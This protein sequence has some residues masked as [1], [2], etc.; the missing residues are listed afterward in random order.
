M[1]NEDLIKGTTIVGLKCDK[2]GCGWRDLN[3]TLNDALD[4]PDRK[5]PD[6]GSALLS[7]EDIKNVR[8]LQLFAVGVSLWSAVQRFFGIKTK[9][10][11]VPV[12]FGP[13]T[14][15]VGEMEEAIIEK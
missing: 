7:K 9:R 4:A 1:E 5:C 12:T 13:S 2:P 3:V 6:C 10:Y 11:S 8:I 14:V 15:E